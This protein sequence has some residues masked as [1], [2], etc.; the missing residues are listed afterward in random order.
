VTVNK[1]SKHRS[2]L[3]VAWVYVC[4][5][6]LLSGFLIYARSWTLE[7]LATPKASD[8]WNHWKHRASQLAG[9]DGPVQRRAPSSNE[10]PGLILLRDHFAV[11]GLAV[12][13][14]GSL[15]FFSTAVALRGVLT[16]SPAI[17]HDVS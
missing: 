12:I 15:L 11:C 17:K 4:F 16:P 3:W 7:T 1:N 13:T 9:D 6:L 14:L 2:Q 10:P 8:D 5:L